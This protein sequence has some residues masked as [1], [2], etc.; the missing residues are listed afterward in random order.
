MPLFQKYFKPRGTYKIKLLNDTWVGQDS[1]EYVDDI[2]ADAATGT[3]VS[4]VTVT[5]TPT[6]LN[7]VVYWDLGTVSWTG[8]TSSNVGY[9]VLYLDTGNTATSPVIDYEDL[10]VSGVGRD[11]VADDLDVIFPSNAIRFHPW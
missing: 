7:G 10:R 4:D 9:A 8:V 2:V 6:L 1:A 5:I 3:G 11:I